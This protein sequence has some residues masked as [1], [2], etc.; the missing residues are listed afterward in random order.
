MCLTSA[1]AHPCSEPVRAFW[2][3][4]HDTQEP[5]TLQPCPQPIYPSSL[6]TG[7]PHPTLGPWPVPFPVRALSRV[8]GST[9]TSGSCSHSTSPGLTQPPKPRELPPLRTPTSIPPGPSQD[10]SHVSSENFFLP[11]SL[12]HGSSMETGSALHMTSS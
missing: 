7:P 1:R 5:P 3:A 9:L 11:A 4:Y 8:Y 12:W 10:W 6:R 2:C